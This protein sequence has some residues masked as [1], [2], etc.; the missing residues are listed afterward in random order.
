MA[1]S[2]VSRGSL[3]QKY[4]IALFGIVVMLLLAKGMS[5]AW[6]G[7]RDQRAMIDALLRSEAESAANKIGAFLDDIKR[8]L[9]WTVQKPWSAGT[10]EQHRLDVLG[11]LR[12][13]PAITGISL[14]DDAGVERLYMSR[15]E[16]DRTASGRDRV[17]DPAVV[18]ART[19]HVWYGP[20]SYYNGSEPFMEIAIAGN[21]RTAGNRYRRHQPQIHMGGHFGYSRRAHGLCRRRG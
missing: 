1:C 10:E 9:G 11:L 19:Q 17:G 5:D 18:G 8:Q 12:Q 14:I 3:F 20:V 6:F 4:F 7:Y 21:R 2:W 16:L 13:V 15:V